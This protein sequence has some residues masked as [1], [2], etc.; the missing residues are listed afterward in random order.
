MGTAGWRGVV[1]R[2][3][4]ALL[5]VTACAPAASPS[6]SDPAP[7]WEPKTAWERAIIDLD[8]NG[9]YS[10]DAALTLFA[11]AYGSL[12]GVEAKQD[13]QGVVD[14]TIAIRAVSRVREELTE[15]QRTAI[16]AHLAVPKEAITIE[17]PPVAQLGPMRLVKADPG[18]EQALREVAE[19]VRMDIAG[20]MGGDFDGF[21]RVA[22]IPRPADVKPVEGL[23]PNGGAQPQY[24]FG[25]FL[26]CQ[27]TIYDEATAQSG[28]QL[29]ALMTHETFHCF[30]QAIHQTQ[31]IHDAAP[32]WITE[33]QATWVGLELGGPSPNYE[34]FWDRYLLQPRI[35]L[36]QRAYDAVGFYAHLAETGTDPWTV[37]RAMLESGTNSLA[38]YLAAGADS[39]AFV[40]SWA[41]GV[42]RDGDPGSAWNTTGPGITSSAYSPLT[43]TVSKGSVFQLSQPFFTNDVD[44]YD[45][46]VDMVQIEIDGHARL[47]DG[48][49]DTAIHGS[50]LYCV[51]GRDCSKVCPGDE[52]R[53]EPPTIGREIR[54]ALS[55]GHEGL[56]GTLRGIALDD[57]ECETPKPSA[58]PPA[59]FEP[60]DDREP[61]QSTCGESNGDV[62][63][64]TLRGDGYDF[65]GVGEFVLARSADGRFEVQTRQAPLS[66][67]KRVSIN[68]ALAVKAGDHRM[69]MYIDVVSSTVRLTVDGAEVPLTAPI[70]FGAGWIVPSA[71]GVRID[72]GDG[73]FV[74]VVG[75]SYRG[76]NLLVEP[77]EARVDATVGLMGRNPEGSRWPA[78]PDGS[79]ILPFPDDRHTEYVQLYQTL[80]DAWRVDQ[81]TS[82]FDYAPGETTETFTVRNF[83]AEADLVYLA[84]LTDA[85]RAAGEAACADVTDE[86]LRRMCVFDVGVTSDPGYGDLYETTLTLLETGQLGASGERLR[87]VNLYAN[88]GRGVPIDVYAWAGD[89]TNFGTDSGTGPALVATVPYGEASEWFNPGQMANGPF[90]PV[91]WIS[92]QR[93]GEPPLGWRFNLMDLP[94]DSKPGLER[95]LVI[96]A[97]PEGFSTVGGTAAE[98]QVLLEESPDGFPFIDPPAGKALGF[99]N[100]HPMFQYDEARYWA[101]SV[102]GQ[103]LADPDFPTLAQT[104]QGFDARAVVLEPGSFEVA[105][106]QWPA[107]ADAFDLNCG[108][109][110]VAARANVTV[111]AGERVHLMVHA[112]NAG[113]PVRLLTLLV[114]D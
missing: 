9:Y 70:A 76:F 58:P 11:T 53:P 81:A 113:A 100:P 3:L 84:D 13:L 50:A 12:P 94:A 18:T 26:G 33:G 19:Q 61:C 88:E 68:T 38:A 57:L 86:E 106:H 112:E 78:L 59:S 64:G 39:E 47:K 77:G 36:T 99:L 34:R 103:C 37:F 72:T 8:E 14:R 80:A 51:E 22:F 15:E 7:Q 85:Q 114:G 104:A 2:A 69:A 25:A 89:A 1:A 24:L 71:E 42:I 93:E 65:Q 73:S 32:H 92:V 27:I 40:D 29:T 109:F 20:K 96:F 5:L 46:D 41:S 74:D 45:L 31:A 54:L 52:E 55:G 90:A 98:Y 66:D 83:P 62:H 17:V 67:S 91:N 4:T 60:P 23:Y 6:P 101:A 63:I 111:R 102:G 107:G 30:Q 110:P 56:I 82:L 44:R 10:K 35:P 16:D 49:T 48:L 75:M 108:R 28:L 105:I 21:L 79:A 97:E 95:V 87:V 43:Y